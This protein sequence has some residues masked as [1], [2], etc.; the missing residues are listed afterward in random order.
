MLI[1]GNLQSH[2]ETLSWYYQ[3]LIKNLGPSFSIEIILRKRG[4]QILALEVTD[5]IL[6]SFQCFHYFDA[7]NIYL[8]QEKFCLTPFHG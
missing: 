5:S 8:H 3:S 4:S 1:L 7:L 6:D 2:K